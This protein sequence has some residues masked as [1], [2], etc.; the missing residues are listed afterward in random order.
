MRTLP[1]FG[2]AWTWVQSWTLNLHGVAFNVGAGR[3]S[4]Q[5]VALPL[6]GAA[7]NADAGDASK[8]SLV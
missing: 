1:S 6:R 2:P 7:C 8:Q 4:K 5:C 3:S